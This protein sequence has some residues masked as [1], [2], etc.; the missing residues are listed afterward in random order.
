MPTTVRYYLTTKAAPVGF[1]PVAFDSSW[2]DTDD[3]LRYSA[4]KVSP[5]VSNFVS[6]TM[7]TSVPTVSIARQ[8]ITDS[9]DLPQGRVSGTVRM[10]QTL[11]TLN[12]AS[13]PTFLR[14]VV[15]VVSADGTIVRGVLFTGQSTNPSSNTPNASSRTISGSLTPVIAYAGDRL[16]VE[17]GASIDYN[18]STTATIYGGTRT[19]TDLPF[20]DGIAS[21]GRR[22][23]VEFIFD[24]LPQSIWEG[25]ETSEEYS[26]G[27]DR[28]VLYPPGIKG[29]PWAGLTSVVEDEVT[30]L[31]PLYFDGVKYAD[32]QTIGSYSARVS[33]FTYPPEL[34]DFYRFGLSYRT[35]EGRYIHLV[36]NVTAKATTRAY[37][38]LS[39]TTAMGDFEWMLSSVPILLNAFRS[40]GHFVIDTQMLS[41]MQLRQL[42]NALYGSATS[43][44][45]LPTVDELAI[46]VQVEGEWIFTDT[47]GGV[48][49]AVG[50]DE[51]YS[52][53]G[54]GRHS[55]IEVDATSLGSGRYSIPA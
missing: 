15:K 24:D 51:L 16:V 6:A 17:I 5:P 54:N 35:N 48:W 34:D 13:A 40:T 19:L 38:T 41:T 49:A 9:N 55:L 22:G 37:Q 39:S 42:E 21:D 8:S 27:V 47:G 30:E 36:Y 14:L 26:A 45:Y 2:T 18:N 33:A 4:E 29:T 52:D 43:D 11:G 46:I 50:P 3:A 10:V 20:S 32:G 1:S 25:H 53:L 44:P 28:G 12:G 31:N 23:W 7:D